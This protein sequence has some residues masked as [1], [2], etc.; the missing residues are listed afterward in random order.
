M[1]KRDREGKAVNNVYVI[2]QVTTM[3]NR[4]GICWGPRSSVLAHLRGEGAGVFIPHIPSFIV[5]MCSWGILIPWHFWP[6]TQ[7]GQADPDSQRKSLSKDMKELSVGS[8]AAMHM[9]GKN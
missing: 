6:A 7:L 8:W 3:G 2:Q 4:G 1:E 5:E 9:S